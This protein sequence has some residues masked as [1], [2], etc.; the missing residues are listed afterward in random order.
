MN[1]LKTFIKEFAIFRAPSDMDDGEFEF[2][3]SRAPR[4]GMEPDGDENPDLDAL[5]PIDGD[6]DPNGAIPAD[7]PC[8]CKCPCDGEQGAPEGDLDALPPPDNID[9]IE[10]RDG[11]DSLDLDGIDGEDKFDF[12][13]DEDDYVFRF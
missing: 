13:K 2:D 10:D 7:D 11:L 4:L 6:V 12:E 9:D 8:K 3:T 5:P 1:N